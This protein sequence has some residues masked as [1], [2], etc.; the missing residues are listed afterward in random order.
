MVQAVVW[1]VH[2][3]PVEE[4]MEVEGEAEVGEWVEVEACPHEVT[5]GCFDALGEDCPYVECPSCGFIFV[6]HC[7]ECIEATEADDD[8]ECM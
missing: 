2:I 8:A 3:V 6:P 7:R 5:F 1:D 4:L